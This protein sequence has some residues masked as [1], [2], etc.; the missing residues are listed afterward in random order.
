M[1]PAEDKAAAAKARM[2]EL[3][4]KFL[5]RSRGDL[6]A[7]RAALASFGAGQAEALGD[8]RHLA[9][10]MVG[11]G[12]TLGFDALAD[13]AARIEELTDAQP[14]GQPPD[15]GVL[16]QIGA[17]LDALDGGIQRQE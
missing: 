2:A 7:M 11:T 1:N 16:S 3:A 9:H 10:R 4:A 13:L 12:A 17:A 15:A 5:E 8:I 6:A 14:P